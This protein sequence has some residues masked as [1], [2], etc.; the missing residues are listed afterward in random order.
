VEHSRRIPTGSLKCNA[1]EDSP[2]R[3]KGEIPKKEEAK[4]GGTLFVAVEVSEM[5]NWEDPVSFRVIGCAIEVHDALG[6]GLLES[7]YQRCLELAFERR[8]LAFEKEKPLTLNFHGLVMPDAYR[9]DFVVENKI[10]VEVKSVRHWEPV[11][12]AQVMTYLRLT[13]LRLG[14]LL[15][16]NVP[17]MADGIKRVVLSLYP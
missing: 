11:F 2:Q 7:A 1:R 16:F 6:P 8:G 4:H 13:K 5:E 10:I 14:L 15:N 3:R 9:A 12:R 17:R